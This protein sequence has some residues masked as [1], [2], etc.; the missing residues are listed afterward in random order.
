VPLAIH[1]GPLWQPLCYA[2]VGGLA[3]ATLVTLVLVPVFYSFFVHDLKVVKWRQLAPQ[4][5]PE[6]A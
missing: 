3:I 1:G 4:A 2:Q 5:A 6:G